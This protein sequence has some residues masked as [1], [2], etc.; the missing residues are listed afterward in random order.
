MNGV[1]D[2]PD[3][4]VLGTG[5]TWLIKLSDKQSDAYHS[6]GSGS[7][8]CTVNYVSAIKFLHY[9]CNSYRQAAHVLHYTANATL[10]LQQYIRTYIVLLGP[11]LCSCVVGLALWVGL[12]GWW[13]MTQ[14]CWWLYIKS[15][16]TVIM[17]GHVRI[18]S[19][20]EVMHTYAHAKLL[21]LR[22]CRLYYNNS[23]CYSMSSVVKYSVLQAVA[24]FW[25]FD[26]YILESTWCLRGSLLHCRWERLGSLIPLC[27]RQ[28]VFHTL[29]LENPTFLMA[30]PVEKPE[31]NTYWACW[32]WANWLWAGS[33]QNP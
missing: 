5:C 9:F 6:M 14:Y 12:C 11:I 32:Y 16:W 3:W 31:L 27:E 21:F 13:C 23:V 15:S 4:W 25:P 28:P 29:E 19:N 24:S 10:S 17:S 30:T 20:L 8:L 18:V 1:T 26:L 2:I 22:T 7:Y 33:K